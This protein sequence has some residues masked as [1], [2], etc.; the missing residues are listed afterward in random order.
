MATSLALQLADTITSRQKLPLLKLRH[1]AVGSKKI[2]KRLKRTD[3]LVIDEISMVENFFFERLNAMLQSARGL[4]TPFGGVQVIVTGDFFQLPPVL[5]FEHCLTCGKETIV[6]RAEDS[7]TCEDHGTW[8]DEDKWAFR[9]EAWNSCNFVY[10]QLETIHRQNDQTFIRILQKIRLG[11]P[12]TTEEETL[13]L[14][15]SHTAKK[16]TELYPTRDEVREVNQANFDRLQTEKYSYSCLDDVDRDEMVYPYLKEIEQRLPDRSLSALSKHRFERVVEL[17]K[18][19]V[20]I[21]LANLDLGRGL[22]NGTQGVIVD[23]EAYDTSKL[24]RPKGLERRLT[25]RELSSSDGKEQE[26]HTVLKETKIRE[27]MERSAIEK[28]FWPVVHFHNGEKRTVYAECSIEQRGDKTPYILLSRTQIPLMPGWASTIHKSQGRT[29]DQ[30][31]VNLNKAW[32]DGQVYVACSRVKTLKGLRIE[33]GRDGLAKASAN[34][35]VK[36]FYQQ[37]FLQDIKNKDGS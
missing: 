1:Y 29:L 10:R 5:P 36:K 13:L 15:P 25:L 28:K 21:L 18:G 34:A 26:K 14:D 16:T 7:Y 31:K 2:R 27:F 30:G 23:F 32:E 4:G 33:G 12:L 37:Q 6:N 9:S 11:N 17:K 35:E 20:V 22:C 24:L 19:M 3:V 8:F